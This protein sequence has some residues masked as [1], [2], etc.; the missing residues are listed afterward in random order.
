MTKRTQQGVV[1]RAAGLQPPWPS[2][3]TPLVV[4]QMPHAVWSM[5]DVHWYGPNAFALLVPFKRRNDCQ[6]LPRAVVPVERVL[7][8]TAE[9]AK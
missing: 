1:T 4:E 2:K 3:D 8:Y 9:K 6:G 7:K 5:L